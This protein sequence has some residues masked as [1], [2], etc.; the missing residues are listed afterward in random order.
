M[1]TGSVVAFAMLLGLFTVIAEAEEYDVRE[2][3]WGMGREEVIEAEGEDYIDE[4]DTQL[5]YE[6]ELLD[7]NAFL[8][9][10]FE[11]GELFSVIYHVQ[12]DITDRLTRALTERYGDPASEGFQRTQWTSDDTVIQLESG[13]EETTLIYGSI[14]MMQEKQR[15][16]AQEDSEGL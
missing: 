10:M 9:T 6:R 4:Q 1:R 2:L 11:E 8:G 3:K 7:H 16:E 13:F 12:S 15:R 14:S 5:T